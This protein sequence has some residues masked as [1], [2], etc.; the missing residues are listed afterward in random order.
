M[1]RGGDPSTLTSA[2]RLECNGANKKAQA[3]L[4]EEA[5]DRNVFDEDGKILLRTRAGGKKKG[6]IGQ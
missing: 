5:Q 6:R 3:T 4:R 1:K 2:K